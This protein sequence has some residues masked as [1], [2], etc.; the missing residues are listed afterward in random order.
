M[1][2]RI[3]GGSSLRSQDHQSLH[4]PALSYRAGATADLWHTNEKLDTSYS[5][6]KCASLI[7]CVM[8]LLYLFPTL[9]SLH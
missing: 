2:T 4:L 5:Q 3:I 1:A 9:L 7:L 8:L 6:I